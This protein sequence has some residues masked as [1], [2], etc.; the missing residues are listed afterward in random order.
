MKVIFAG[1]VYTLASTTHGLQVYDT[2]ELL[3]TPCDCVL[4]AL[5]VDA[6]T[7]ILIPCGMRSDQVYMNPSFRIM[8]EFTVLLFIEAI[9]MVESTRT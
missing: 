9:C 6:D 2:F 1:G 4:G 8:C 7:A 5:A 3:F